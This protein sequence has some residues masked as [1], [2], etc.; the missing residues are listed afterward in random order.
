VKKEFK[1]SRDALY[2]KLL[3][4]GIRTTVHYKPLHMFSVMKKKAKTS[5]DE[6]INSKQIYQQA[7]SLPLYP[8]ISK[9]QQD[10][11]IQALT[12]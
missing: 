11:V 3:K 12:S 7:L 6:L 5:Y 9:K 8:E 4:S 2:S 1:I 10:L